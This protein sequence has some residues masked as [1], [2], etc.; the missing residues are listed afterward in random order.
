MSRAQYFVL[1][2]LVMVGAFAGSFVANRG[3]AVVHAQDRVGPTNVRGT[4]FTLINPQGQ[5]QGTLRGGAMGAQLE[6]DDAN[7]KPRVQIGTSGIAI[8]DA[9]GQTVWSSPK[10]S[11]CLVPATPE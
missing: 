2:A 4:S 5:V 9:I 3:I 1:C 6:L 10:C 8:R 7:G 11:A